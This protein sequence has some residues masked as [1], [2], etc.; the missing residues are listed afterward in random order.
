MSV[1]FVLIHSPL[2]GPYTWQ[3]V[4]TELREGGERVVVP[5][6]R[7][8]RRT[9]GHYWQSHV[10]AVV[11]SI[12]ADDH[13]GQTVLV[14][15]SGAGSLVPAILAQLGER[16]TGCIL[17]DAGLPHPGR[18]R[19]ETFEDAAAVEQFRASA[20]DGMLRPPWT[21]ADLRPLIPDGGVRAAFFADIAPM[22]ADVYEEAMPPIELP[23]AVRSAYL[24][25]SEAYRSHFE[26]ARELGWSTAEL[27]GGHFEMLA[28]PDAVAGA[29]RELASAMR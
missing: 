26:R 25:F 19:F 4:A 5:E 7:S 10:N 3:R 22:A 12:A 18:S 13:P 27:S 11:H 21:E 28:R 2:V 1:T 23:P 15:Y 17:A 9:E 8:A 6:L 14:A 20:R 16:V 29:L 24:L